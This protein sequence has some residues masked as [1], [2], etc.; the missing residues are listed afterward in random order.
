MNPLIQCVKDVIPTVRSF[1]HLLHRHPELSGR[2]HETCRFI[3]ETLKTTAFRVSPPFLATD[4]VAL[5][6]SNRRPGKHI[7]L[8]A[9]ID[10]LPQEECN[11][12]LEYRSQIPGAMHGCGHDAHAAM[13]LG[14]ALVLDKL[15]DSWQGSVK[16]VFQPGEEFGALGHELVKAGALA[17]PE[18]DMIFA[19]HGMPGFPVGA[20]ISRS[21]PITAAADYYR[22]TITGKGGHASSPHKSVD[23]VVIAAQ[24]ITAWQTIVTRRMPPQ[25]TVV[26]GTGNV[27]CDGAWN[28]IPERVT[29]EGT[30]RYYNK[31]L[32]EEIEKDMRAIAEGIAGGMRG[33]AE[34]EYARPYIP[35]VNRDSAI[36]YSRRQLQQ[37]LPELRLL[38]LPE[39]QTIGEDFSFYLD[40]YPGALYLLG[41]GEEH[42]PLHHTAFD[43]DDDALFHGILF[44]CAMA[45]WS[46]P[47]TV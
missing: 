34:L 30:V 10:A 7:V 26:I 12:A 25:E 8:R 17:E 32:G 46:R 42:L 36:A 3:R 11:P 31:W 13:L 1:R 23:P 19:L 5:L 9:D 35:T 28:I 20:L 22:L 45:D 15:Q 21:G 18:P 41:L 37:L 14:A 16:L 27:Q 40:R 43:F 4:T 44:L 2:E 33:R 29:L 38:E 6:H 24:I 47:G 39:P